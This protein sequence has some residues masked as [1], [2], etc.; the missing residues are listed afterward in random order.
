MYKHLLIFGMGLVCLAS[1]SGCIGRA[2]NEGAGVAFGASGKVTDLHKPEKLT[3]YKGLKVETLTVSQGL[4]VPGKMVTYLRESMHKSAG[5]MGL[6]SDRRPILLLTGEVIHYES[7]SV[8][9]QAIGP[10]QEVIL[11]TQLRDADTQAVLAE[12]NLIGRA[13]ATTSGGSENLAE[14]VGKA[15]RKWLESAGFKEAKKE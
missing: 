9:D 8:V 15:L 6:P 14:G 2:I 12:S 13:R 1:T 7:G 4:D 10:L 11:R 5:E 3:D